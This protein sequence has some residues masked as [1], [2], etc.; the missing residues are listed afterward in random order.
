MASRRWTIKMA[1]ENRGN[2]ERK[3][4]TLLL[5]RIGRFSGRQM[6]PQPKHQAELG[7]DSLNLPRAMS[8]SSS[9]R[10]H[11]SPPNCTK[12]KPETLQYNRA[13][14]CFVLP[15]NDDRRQLKRRAEI[16]A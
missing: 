2:S 7:L 5:I 14:Q 8:V 6:P 9:A 3:V 15:I 12:I 1:T 4:L 16:V 13:A 11:T 10:E